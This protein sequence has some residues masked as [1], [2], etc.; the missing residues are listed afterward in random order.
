[1]QL[2]ERHKIKPSH[3]LW[4][5]IDKLCF[6]SKNLYNY[7]NYQIRQSFI[8]ERVYLGYNQLYHLVKGTPDYK[9]LPAQRVAQIVV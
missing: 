8:F 7:A 2:V 5:Q 3:Q 6:L 1:M 4:Q 9:A